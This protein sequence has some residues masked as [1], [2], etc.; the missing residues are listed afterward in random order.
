V[1]EN[2]VAGGAGS[3]VAEF[4]AAQGIVVPILQLGLPDKLIDHASHQQQ[5]AAVGLDVTGIQTAIDERLQL[6]ALPK[7]ARQ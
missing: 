7:Q 4:L 3:A 1:E 5:L 2:S 6:L